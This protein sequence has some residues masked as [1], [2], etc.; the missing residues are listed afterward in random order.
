MQRRIWEA[1]SK[2]LEAPPIFYLA[3]YPLQS[4]CHTVESFNL[5]LSKMFS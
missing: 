3:D 2:Y 4:I 5:E 1:L